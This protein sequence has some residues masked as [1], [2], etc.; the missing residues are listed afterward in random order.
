MSLASGVNNPAIDNLIQFSLASENK[1]SRLEWIPCSQII[2]IKPTQMDNVYYAYVRTT[3]M[4]LFLGNSGECTQKLVDEFARIYSL[5]TH[6]HK[7]NDSHFRRYS[8]WLESRNSLIIGFTKYEDKYYMVA[9]P[10][11]YGCY[12][13][14]GFC[15]A[16]QILRCSPVWCICGN[17]QLSNGWTSNNEQLDD[18]IKESQLRTNSPNH[19]YLEWIPLDCIVDIS[20]YGYRY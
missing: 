17:K 1:N 11:F 5:P 6:K 20:K 7:N 14:Y 4:L 3:V 15:T 10:L 2:N 18:F 19:A 12:S 13:R 16:C 8:K 9:R